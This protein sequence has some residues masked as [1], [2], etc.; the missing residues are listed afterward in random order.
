MY[1]PACYAREVLPKNAMIIFIQTG[2]NNICCLRDRIGLM[3]A[4]NQN[5]MMPRVATVS[6]SYMPD[7]C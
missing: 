6:D 7:R 4:F 2:K 1:I 5:L 3:V